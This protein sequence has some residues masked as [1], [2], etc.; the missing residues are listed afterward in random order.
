MTD[1]KIICKS[2]ACCGL[3]KAAREIKTDIDA[4]CT[5]DPAATGRAEVLL[6][7]SGLH[8]LLMHRL[9]H[10]LQKKGKY[11]SARAISQFAKFLTGIEIHPGAVIGKGL[12]IDHGS[13]VV[14]G[15]T[16]IIGDNCTIYQG[17]TLGGTGKQTGK[18]H[19][20]LG[21]NV[22]I[23][24]GAKLLGN[25]T[26]GDNTKIAAGAVVLGDVPANSTAVGIPAKVVRRGGEKVTDGIDL[27][28]VHIPDPVQNEISAIWEKLRALEAKEFGE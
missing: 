23:G 15:E 2:K 3:F 11:F 17:V 24:A 14:I 19:P 5:R 18:R 12:F 25:F 10:I 8:A 22:M 7:Y 21:N 9:A 16:T 4:I 27:D 1:I 20:T 6:L 13:G 28:Q 26:I